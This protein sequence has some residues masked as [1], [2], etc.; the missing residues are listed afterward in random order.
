MR[1]SIAMMSLVISKPYRE[2]IPEGVPIVTTAASWAAKYEEWL[3][4]SSALGMI[5]AITG[6]VNAADWVQETMFA[7]MYRGVSSTQR[8]GTVTPA[9]GTETTM[10]TASRTYCR[11]YCFD[12]SLNI[13]SSNAADYL[14]DSGRFECIYAPSEYKFNV[15][16]MMDEAYDLYMMN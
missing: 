1:S 3:T 7:Q 14:V 13:T 12:D 5:S 6:I 4:V 11:Y 15:V 2:P 10:V 16:T 9:N 8:F